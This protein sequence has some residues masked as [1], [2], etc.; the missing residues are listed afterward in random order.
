[1]KINKD[2]VLRIGEY[3]SALT[4]MTLLGDYN[5]VLTMLIAKY[6]GKIVF[7][8]ILIIIIFSF[9]H[10]LRSGFLSAFK[11]KIYY[12][13]DEYL[14]S[15]DISFLICLI[16]GHILSKSGIYITSFLIFSICVVNDIETM[17]LI[18]LF[19]FSTHADINNLDKE[20]VKLFDVYNDNFILDKNIVVEEKAATYD[21]LNRDLIINELKDA[22]ILEHGENAFTI[23]VEGE[24]GSGK[25][26]LINLALDR[27]KNKDNEHVKIISDFDPWI[28]GSNESLLEGLYEEILKCIGVK[29]NSFKFR[30]DIKKLI[31]IVANASK[32][33]WIDKLFDDHFGYSDLKRMKNELTKILIR[34]NAVIV[35]VLDNLDRMDSENVLFLF[36]LI[37]TVFDLPHINYVL[38]YDDKRLDDIFSESLKINPKY[39]EKIISQIIRVPKPDQDKLHEVYTACISNILSKKSIVRIE[40]ISDYIDFL[41]KKV[42]DLR[43]FIRIINSSINRAFFYY[44]V[45]NLNE[46]LILELIRFK[47]KRLYELIKRNANI[48]I[49]QDTLLSKD[50]FSTHLDQEDYRQ[51]K[52]DLLI[53]LKNNYPDEVDMIVYL[54]P[55]LQENNLRETKLDTISIRSAKY[56]YLYFSYGSNDFLL[57]Y[58]KVNLFIQAINKSMSLEDIEN[59]AKELEIFDVHESVQFEMV[60]EISSQMTMLDPKRNFNLLCFLWNHFYDFYDTTH[61]LRSARRIALDIIYDLI[62]Q[63]NID[64]VKR[65]IKLKEHA[66]DHFRIISNIKQK[67]D[68]SGNELVTKLWSQYYEKLRAKIIETPVNLYCDEFYNEGNIWGLLANDEI[69]GETLQKYVGEVY[70]PKY[71]YRVLGDVVGCNDNGNGNYSYG[72]NE[73]FFNILAINET[74]I[75][76]SLQEY[77]PVND[78]QKFVMNLYQGFKNG[79][80]AKMGIYPVHLNKPFFIKDL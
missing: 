61:L 48:L 1:M 9:F 70:D 29:Y 46:F 3:T 75:D 60:S 19:H 53:L 11:I 56:F 43:N 33:T 40:D 52:H 78:S 24:W 17:R 37:G 62:E 10:I 34:E 32:E 28:F 73:R 2:I 16:V 22:M 15:I 35:I 44:L 77:K 63:G 66:Y 23:G 74:I 72:I 47:N 49:S 12:K 65:F 27:I 51:K 31:S 4:F 54:F 76:R 68:L 58:H 8:G 30:Q 41:S 20:L 6:R 80:K 38:S 64:E 67:L 42:S 36:K 5:N 55:D 69:E 25:T 14:L 18:Y 26:T 39:K 71:V 79:E 7:T 13:I 57:I 45:L 59:A 21:L 50:V